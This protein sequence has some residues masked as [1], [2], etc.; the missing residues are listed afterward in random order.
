MSDKEEK[1]AKATPQTSKPGSRTASPTPVAATLAVPTALPTEAPPP[2]VEKRATRSSSP[3]GLSMELTFKAKS[4]MSRVE[5]LRRIM[6]KMPEMLDETT[7]KDIESISAQVDEIHKLFQKEHA[8][9]EVTWPASQASHPYLKEDYYELEMG[10]VLEVRRRL[11]K[12]RVAFEKLRERRGEST[13]RRTPS[14]LPELTLPTFTG[15]Y[16]AWPAF[17]ELFAS[18]II[19][20]ER[21]SNVERL[22]YLRSCLRSESL[23]VIANLPSTGESFPIAW[24]NLK[25]R[26]EN[27]RIIISSLLDKL[28]STSPVQQRTAAAYH[29]VA[30]NLR[31]YNTSLRALASP[32]EL[33]NCTL[34]HVMSR[35]LVKTTREAWETSL[36]TTTEF[37][38]PEKLEEFLTTKARALERV[39][40][41]AAAQAHA[42]AKAKTTGQRPALTTT[43]AATIA[44]ASAHAYPCDC[45][46]EDHFVISCTKFRAMTVPERRRL[47]DK[48]SLCPQTQWVNDPAQPPT[49]DQRSCSLATQAELTLL[50]TANAQVIT[51]SATH[52]ARLLVDS[53][54][55]LSFVSEDLVEQLGLQRTQ[56]TISIT[57]IGGKKSTQ[58]RVLIQ[59]HILR[60]LTATLPSSEALKEDWPHLN[61]LKLAD[62]DF[63]KPRARV[64][65]S[66][67]ATIFQDSDAALREL[68]T[69]FWIQEEPPTETTSQLT[70]EE[71]ECENHFLATHGRDTTGRYVARIP[72]KSNTKV[73]G[74]SYSTARSC[75]RRT[76]NKLSR[77]PEYREQYQ[78]F[79]SEYED[80]GH[81]K[82]ASSISLNDSSIYYLPHHGVFKPD[83]E[84]TKL[85][86][87]F[88][89]SSPTT[90]GLSVDDIMHTGA[91]LLLNI[92]DVLLWIRHHKCIFATDITKMYRQVRVH[93]DDW[94]LQR[95]LWIDEESN[96]V[97][98]T[99]TTVTY[100]TK[101][102]PFLAV[103]AL[104]QLAEDEGQRYLLAVPSIKHARYV[105][106]IFGGADSLDSL[107]EIASQLTDL[108]NAG[109]FP[110]AKWHSNEASLL[111]TI[112]PCNNSQGTS[113]SLDDCNTKTLG[114]RWNTVNDSFTF[115]TKS[116]HNLNFT[117]RL[118]LSEVV[119]I[120]DPLGFLSPV[121]IRAKVL[122][123]E[124]WL[125][126]LKWDDP[127]PSHVTTRWIA[128]RED[129]T[130]LAR[131]SIPR[132]FNTYNNS[133]V[134]LH[135]FSDA[136]QLAMA[137]VIYITVFSPF[138]DLKVTSLVCSKTKV[139]PLKKLTIPRLELTAALIFA[140]LLK[141]VQANLK[142]NIAAI[143]LWTDSQVTLTWIKSHASRWKDYVRNRVTQIQ[144]LT[145]T[146][147]WMH[148][149]GT[150]NP[151]DCA[152]RG[153]TT[154]QLEQHELWWRGPPWLLQS[155]ESWPVQRNASDDTCLQECRPG[156]SHVL[157]FISKL[158]NTTAS[159]RL[160]NT[161]A[162]L[163]KAKIFWIKATQSAYFSHELKM[164]VNNQTLPSSHAF[165]RLT[166]FID[167]Q[168]VIRVGGRL[169]NAQLTY[170]DSALKSMFVEGTQ[171]NQRLAKLFVDD[172]TTWSFNPPA[173]P[174]MGGKWEAVV[175]SV[176]YHLR[177]TQSQHCLSH[178]LNRPTSHREP[179]G[180][181]YNKNYNNSGSAGQLN[182]SNGCNQSLSGSTLP[183]TSTLDLWCCLQT[184]ASHHASGLLLECSQFTLDQMD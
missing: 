86:V 100:G 157:T 55:E 75:L 143:H 164:M 78:R 38:K 166:A 40:L 92:T 76:L 35:S 34:V 171:D 108:C 142:L 66:F 11:G 17:C 103:R 30:A 89:G 137:A 14:K 61:R 46:Q 175:K 130:S 53:G 94:N 145:Q 28:F 139:A 112:V 65:S 127:L 173:A 19:D 124:L 56:S 73:L 7:P 98:Y 22:H 136:S 106:N 47:V 67:N 105:D 1:P 62:P 184:S 172:H 42:Q 57:G 167:D 71:Q 144:E 77:N 119:Q 81:M 129:L 69:K 23:R 138:T 155:Q 24:A 50:A 31:D 84:T 97:P 141:Y 101:A 180:I 169:S 32:E 174:H 156:I 132:W 134:E 79:M 83:S 150:S 60:T 59:T 104:L 52:N 16:E 82:K 25:Q 90:T 135:G 27:K 122:L 120:F 33:W 115:T 160:S 26:Y 140:K 128:I 123:Q 161:P 96:E 37:P 178:L 111:E 148:V 44:R 12:F 2:T 107:I 4:Q 74:T 183:T 70:P 51:S 43:Q 95:I 63:Y 5:M 153:L 165:N 179:G 80:L 87:V 102:A 159:T 99:L 117:K 151:A 21:L 181:S 109:G 18:I 29:N 114:L 177:R 41:P 113:I 93:E 182:I 8:Y 39:E 118:V 72:L 110:L 9:L 126:N 154:T 49:P 121:I 20:N 10:V 168:G 45:C 48:L 146:A 149:P 68:L 125:L 158:R 85:R 36:G 170:E 163:E 176:K 133:T 147:T 54:S 64:Y 13:A 88:N 6:D 162:D 3:A 116:H 152:S 58:T 91:N 15:R 131:L